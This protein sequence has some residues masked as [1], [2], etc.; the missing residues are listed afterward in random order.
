[1]SSR[2]DK[3][4]AAI[5][6]AVTF[7]IVALLLV[8]LFSCSLTW[9]RAAIAQ[10]SIPE[11]QSDEELFIDPELID[12]GEK[13]SPEIDEATPAEAGEPEKGEVEERRTIEKGENP[14]PAP[15]VEKKVTQK[16]E[17]TVKTPE[18]SADEKERKKATSKVAAGFSGKSGVTDGKFQSQSGAGATG[19]GI[20]GNARG[21]TFLGCPKPVVELQNKTVVR[22]DVVVDEEGKVIS[23]SASG[24]ASAA[25]RRKCE[26][27]ARQARWSAK[28]G[29]GETRGSITFTITPR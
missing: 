14:K 4:A 28:K 17:S 16:Q 15:P 12:L 9:D 13:T 20:S 7:F 25:I 29:S 26:Q 5:A 3:K 22:V 23:A 27:S 1:M 21:R 18:P 2:Q 6:A 10:S 24:S 11:E 8:V 19:V